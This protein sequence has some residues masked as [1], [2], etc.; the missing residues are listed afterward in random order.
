MDDYLLESSYDHT[1]NIYGSFKQSNKQ[2]HIIS[3]GDIIARYL[4]YSK[5]HLYSK[6]IYNG[7]PLKIKSPTIL[8][9]P[10]IYQDIVHIKNRNNPLFTYT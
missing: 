10:S 9:S 8:L 1:Y 3:D 7:E 4:N 5:I 2:L 6:N